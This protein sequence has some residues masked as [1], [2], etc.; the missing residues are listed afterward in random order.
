MQTL[1]TMTLET[2][3]SDAQEVG[4]QAIEFWCTV[5]PGD[6]G[7]PVQCQPPRRCFRARGSCSEARS[8]VLF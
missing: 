6:R 1:F 2:A 3:R 7:A 5:R 4:V 8:L